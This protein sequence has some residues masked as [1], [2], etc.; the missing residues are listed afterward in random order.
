MIYNENNETKKK[1]KKFTHTSK[2]IYNQIDLF[3]FY[4]WN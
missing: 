1:K 2:Y 4:E 3:P